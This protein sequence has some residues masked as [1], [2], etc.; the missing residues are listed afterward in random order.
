MY[1][2]IISDGKN[3]IENKNF[4]LFG[5]LFYFLRRI[6]FNGGNRLYQVLLVAS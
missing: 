2:G 5:I 1:Y 3:K 4:R 6:K